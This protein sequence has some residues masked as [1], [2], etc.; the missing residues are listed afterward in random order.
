MLHFDVNFGDIFI[1]FLFV[2]QMLFCCKTFKLTEFFG[3]KNWTKSSVWY[4][5]QKR[6]KWKTTDFITLN[7][8]AT[9]FQAIK[10]CCY[11]IF[12]GCCLSWCT[13][14][15]PLKSFLKGQKNERNY[16]LH[17]NNFCDWLKNWSNPNDEWHLWVLIENGTGKKL[18]MTTF[19]CFLWYAGQMA[20]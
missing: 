4:T 6:F 8:A 7:C 19:W 1:S 17:N 9:A 11:F 15:I 18:M 10:I 20:R 3:D 5:K 2:A 14:L 16:I 12:S 13:F